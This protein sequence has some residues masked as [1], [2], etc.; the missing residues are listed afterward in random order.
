MKNFASRIWADEAGVLTFEWILL[1]TVLVIGI[2]GALSA[3]RD[4]MNCELGDVAEAMI[5]LDQSYYI[6][7]PWE[8]NT[9]DG[10]VW[11]GGSN[12]AFVDEGFMDQLRANADGDADTTFKPTQTVTVVG[13]TETGAYVRD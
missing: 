1:V 6:L 8:V 10:Q 5:A 13:E 11:D 4:A 7:W 3:V 2:T 9:P 12:S